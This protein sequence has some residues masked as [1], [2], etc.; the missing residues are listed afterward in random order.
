MRA[1]YNRGRMSLIA[2]QRLGP[3][4]IIAALGEGGMGEVYRA[5]DTRLGRDVA[6]KILPQRFASDPA[7]VERFDR[8]ARAVAAL[9][10]PHI[11][12]I[13]DIGH[14]A[15][16]TFAVTELLEGETLRDR[17]Q[18]G[19]LPVRKAVDLGGQIAQGLSA[20][21]AKGIIHRDLKPENIFITRDGH[22]KILDFGL[23]KVQPVAGEDRTQTA[24]PTDPGT[25]LG[26]T[27]YLSPEQAQARPIDTRSDTFSFG[28][29][30]YEM[31][32]GARAFK[33]DSTIDTLH[34]IVHNQPPPI[35]TSAPEVPTELRW[36]LDKCLAKDPDDRYQSTRDLVVD[37][38]NV[39]RTLDSS[40]AL[41]VTPAAVH[42]APKRS[43][44]FIAGAA[45]AA[46]AIL[47]AAG[48][49]WRVSMAR[50]PADAMPSK[51][52]IERVT[53]LGTV[54]DAAVSP[55]GKYVVYA[56]AEDR[57]STRL[58]SSH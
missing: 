55:D 15:G 51:L 23:A 54:I 5:R 46:L 6:I 34:S 43:R 25:V 47:F 31:L 50:R 17:L 38:K 14:D 24:A 11:V 30:L 20:A 45:I 32:A 39:A 9:S 3:Y 13:H 53:S 28:A 8:E 26:T 10:H 57:K 49:A 58:N 1:T 36:I 18:S 44:A 4:E 22:A 27:G 21:H 48:V 7:A 40:P 12:A 35:A 29:V 33:G 2:G 37:L 16:V 41:P 56:T 52:S 19:R 42:A